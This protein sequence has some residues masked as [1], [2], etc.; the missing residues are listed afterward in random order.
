MRKLY[1]TAATKGNVVCSNKSPDS[2]MHPK[3][4]RYSKGRQRAQNLNNIKKKKS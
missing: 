4:L 3:L 2:R 1:Q